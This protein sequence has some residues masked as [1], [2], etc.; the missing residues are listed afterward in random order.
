MS[1]M[2]HPDTS[3]SENLSVTAAAAVAVVRAIEK[4]TD[5]RP[6]IKWVNDIFINGKK[7]CGILT[8]A[9]TDFESGTDLSVIV[10]IG[11][12]VT[13]ESFPPEVGGNGG[14]YRRI[15]A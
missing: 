10:G 2:Y 3:L 12:N 15:A 7:V 9:V 11:I 8:E 4:L 1:L 14:K 13:T 6:Q 5:M